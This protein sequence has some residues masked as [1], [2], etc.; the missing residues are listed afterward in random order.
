L[1]LCFLR[2][3]GLFQYINEDGFFVLSSGISVM[4]MFFSALFFLTASWREE[5]LGVF[6]HMNYEPGDSCLKITGLLK[7][8]FRFCFDF[9]CAYFLIGAALLVLFLADTNWLGLTETSG[10]TALSFNDYNVLRGF[11]GICCFLLI[12]PSCFYFS[13]SMPW[14]SFFQSFFLLCG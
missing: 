14:L 7:S 11:G 5:E 4:I 6:K 13:S 1:S 2:I 8:A 9:L 10:R 3:F 12:R